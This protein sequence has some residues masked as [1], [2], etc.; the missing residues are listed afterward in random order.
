MQS[1]TFLP[2]NIVISFYGWWCV[3]NL[4]TAHSKVAIRV[5][6]LESLDSKSTFNLV[7]Y[8]DVLQGSKVGAH[9]QLSLTG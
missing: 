2:A 1:C 4:S 5:Y 9:D 8:K 6:S 7:G 3:N